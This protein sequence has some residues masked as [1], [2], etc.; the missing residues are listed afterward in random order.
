MMNLSRWSKKKFYY[1][2]NPF[3]FSCFKKEFA[4]VAMRCMNRSKNSMFEKRN[5]DLDRWISEYKN[6]K[7]FEYWIMNYDE[8]NKERIKLNAKKQKSNLRNNRIIEF[9][10]D[11]LFYLCCYY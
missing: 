9:W 6:K 2:P 4:M 8:T 7:F 11:I 10:I 3:Q 1:L 5:W